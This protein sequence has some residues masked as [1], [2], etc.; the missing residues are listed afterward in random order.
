MSLVILVT[1]QSALGDTMEKCGDERESVE[2]N[3]VTEQKLCHVKL[4]EINSSNQN[5]RS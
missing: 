5:L 4:R 3:C 1:D 2:H